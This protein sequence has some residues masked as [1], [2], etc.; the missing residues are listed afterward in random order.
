[1]GL[2]KLPTVSIGY[3]TGREVL[4]KR[5]MRVWR[6][7]LNAIF[8]VIVQIRVGGLHL[9]S[10]HREQFKLRGEAKHFNKLQVF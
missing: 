3:C 2:V 9:I 6:N 4:I 8:Y 7:I 1:M 5:C 10:K